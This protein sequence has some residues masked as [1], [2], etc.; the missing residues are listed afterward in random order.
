MTERAV[1]W[2]GHALILARFR[3]VLAVI[4]WAVQFC[5]V[6]ASPRGGI[7]FC[8]HDPVILAKIGRQEAIEIG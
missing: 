7:F 4:G 2:I 5:P 3:E 8:V 6:C 1:V